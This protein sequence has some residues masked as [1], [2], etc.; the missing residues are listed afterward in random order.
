LFGGPTDI[1]A[2]YP[3]AGGGSTSFDP[4]Q[5]EERAALLEVNGSI[6]TSWTSHCDNAP[7]TGWI[8]SFDAKTLA[9]TGVLNI[10]PNSGGLGPAIW[11]AGD[12][13]GADASGNIYLL[14]ANGVFETTLDANGFPNKQDYG[15]SFVK[16]AS[17][18]LTVTD[19]FAMSN[20]L[21]E[22]QVDADL[23]SGGQML[24]PDLTDSGGAVRHLVIGAGKDGTI[25]LV[26]RDSMGK[27]STT[28]N[29]IWQELDNAVPGGVFS[30]PA[31]FNGAV[32]YGDAGGTLKAFPVSAAKLA[33]A[34][35]S[36]S[37]TH[38]T[39]PGTSPAIS[40][41]GTANGI[42]WAVE[43][44]NPAV[45][46]AYDASSLSHELYNSNQAANNR[47]HFGSGNKFVAP[48]IADGKVF[49]ATPNSVAIFGLL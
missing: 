48:S 41:N 15:N 40:A 35:S 26:N 20:E 32:Y 29:N 27:F 22:S 8:I 39:F 10:A 2:T 42:V 24:R 25:Y 6:V 34:A 37:A 18:G 47:D 33:A 3:T 1:S 19:Y 9:R 14:A 23:G 45:L 28:G 30:T 4:G 21:A 43:N 38:F 16:I 46:H 11:M 5:Y 13:P 36:Q 7:Y 17:S 12:G 44:S 31:Y 49:V